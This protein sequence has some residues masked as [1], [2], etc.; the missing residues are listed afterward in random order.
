M[1]KQ[2]KLAI[3]MSIFVLVIVISFSLILLNEK[4]LPYITDRIDLKFTNY[5]ETNYQNILD[6]LKVEKTTYT[7]STYQAIVSSKENPNLH[8][9]LI[10]KNKKVTDTYKKDYLE[11]NTILKN[12]STTLEKDL[13]KKYGYDFKVVNLASLDTYNDEL[14]DYIIKYNSFS[15]LKIYTLEISYKTTMNA[16][17]LSNTISNTYTELLTES[18]IP[19]S[20]TFILTDSKDITKTVKIENLTSK[21]IEDKTTLNKIIDAIINDENKEVLTNNNISYEYL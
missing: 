20:Y 12:I 14:K 17:D 11:G 2:K 6:D 10:Y 8:F 13:K 1:Q 5:L 7:N 16:K 3:Q 21:I 9:T 4:D 18:V 15:D 19:K